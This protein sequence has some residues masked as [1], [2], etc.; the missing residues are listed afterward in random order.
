M[1]LYR[2][3]SRD[4]EEVV[5]NPADREPDGKGNAR[6]SGDTGDGRRI[7]VVVSEDDPEFV[8]TVFP[9]G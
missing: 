9:R 5:A 2:L 4:V 8:I 6:L 7:L 1:R 3:A